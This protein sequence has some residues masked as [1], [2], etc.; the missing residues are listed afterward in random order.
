MHKE[1]LTQRSF[2]TKQTFTH[3]KRTQQTFTQRSCYTGCAKIEKILLPKHPLHFTIY[4]SQLQNT[5]E[6]RRHPQQRGTL[7]QPFHFD[8]QRQSCKTQ[9]IYAQR[10]HKLQLCA[11][12]KP[13]LDAKAEL[14]DPIIPQ[15]TFFQQA[16]TKSSSGTGEE[17]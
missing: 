8:L 14:K 11:A 10:L 17:G 5:K 3:S 13:D 6:L 12:P 9:K 1:A 15:V 2:Y 16:E 7:T 4:D